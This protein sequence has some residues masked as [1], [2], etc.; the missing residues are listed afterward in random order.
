MQTIK[1]KVTCAWCNSET[2]RNLEPYESHSICPRHKAQLLA[3]YKRDCEARDV[4]KTFSDLERARAYRYPAPVRNDVLE[5]AWNAPEPTVWS[6]LKWVGFGVL[7]GL[8]GVLMVLAMAW[9]SLP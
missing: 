7:C 2:G 8:A 6:A 9:E 4:A 1:P 5:A 3:E